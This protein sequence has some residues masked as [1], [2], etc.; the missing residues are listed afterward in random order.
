MLAP[1]DRGP[2]VE[3]TPTFSAESFIPYGKKILLALPWH[4]S[5]SPLTSFCVAQL[6]DRRRTASMLAYGDAFIAHTRNTCVDVFLGSSVCEW[7]LFIDDD[8]IVPFGDAN[9]FRANTGFNFPEKFM[10]LNALD[11]LMAA[12]KTLVGATY[13]GKH[14]NAHAVFNEGAD[15]VLGAHVRKGPHD[16]VRATRWVG[17]GCML[18][19]RSVFEDIEKKFPMLARKGPRGGNWFTSTEASLMTDLQQLQADFDSETTAREMHAALE[20]IIAKAEQ[21]NVMGYGEDVSFCL[22]A[23]S[24]GHPAHV[25]FGL[26]CG[27]VGGC[28]YG[29]SNTVKK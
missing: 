28:V 18:A 5:V 23:L 19:H 14:T 15:P 11:R 13:Y 20:R 6:T 29:P 10:S 9:W 27:H 17:T 4:K 16:E 3:P 21:E 1:A 22:R 8:M 2:G 12:G 24:A 26:V 25:D 7:I